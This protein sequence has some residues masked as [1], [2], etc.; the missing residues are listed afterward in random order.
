MDISSDGEGTLVPSLS[1]QFSPGQ[2]N[3]TLTQCGLLPDR[4]EELA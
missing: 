2:V 4:T 3:R 1:R